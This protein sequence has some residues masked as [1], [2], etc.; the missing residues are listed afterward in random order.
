MAIGVVLVLAT[1]IQYSHR[2]RGALS[3]GVLHFC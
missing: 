1:I 2:A 3:A